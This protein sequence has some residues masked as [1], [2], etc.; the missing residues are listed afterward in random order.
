MV[1]KLGFGTLGPKDI[2]RGLVYLGLSANVVVQ[3]ISSILY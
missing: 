1:V 3:K 2:K